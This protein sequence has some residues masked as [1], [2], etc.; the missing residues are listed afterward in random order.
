MRFQLFIPLTLALAVFA[1]DQP[2]HTPGAGINFYSLDREIALGADVAEAVRRETKALDS[3]LARDYVARLGRQLALETPGPKFPYTFTVLANLP[4]SMSDNPTHEPMALPGGPIFIPASLI[5][6]A[7][8]TSE[9]AGMLAHAIAHVADRDCTRS[10]TRAD[11]M[12]L[13]AVA[14]VQS[15]GCWVG[16]GA[17]P[18]GYLSFQQAFERQ[19]DYLAVQIM[20][21]AGYDPLAMAAYIRRAQQAPG[22]QTA[23][24]RGFSPWPAAEERIQQIDKEIRKLSPDRRYSVGEDIQPIQLEV[25]NLAAK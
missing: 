12:Q 3:D 4:A 13:G 8:D 6:E 21:K 18:L 11:L 22:R 20:A 7:Q 24:S 10:K 5:L 14:D 1:Q 19:A 9:L 25:R 15:P 23:I 17:V 2:A 16:Q